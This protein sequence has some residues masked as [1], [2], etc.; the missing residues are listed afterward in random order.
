MNKLSKIDRKSY[1]FLVDL[2]NKFRLAW[3]LIK[4]N[5][6]PFSAKLVPIMILL[7][8]I[9]PIDILPDALPII[10]QLDDLALILLG[11][12]LFI[13]ISPQIIVQNYKKS[14]VSK[15]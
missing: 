1:G 2:I 4:D 10:G 5:K 14:F 6:V 8:I 9:S 7:Y 15:A 11:L 13:N 3:Y 12:E